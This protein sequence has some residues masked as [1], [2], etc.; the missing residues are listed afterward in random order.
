M[1][2]RILYFGH[3]SLAIY[4][5][6][7]LLD[8]GAEVVAVVPTTT[9]NAGEGH[10][11]EARSL[12]R[13][14][15]S[16][17]LRVERLPN[18]NSAAARA[19]LAALEPDLL[20]SVHYDRIFTPAVL[21]LPRLGA[22]NLHLSPLPRLRGCYPTKWAI[23]E[24][25]DA[26]VT[27]HCMDEGVDTGSIID[28]RIVPLEVAETDQSLTARLDAEARQLLDEHVPKWARG[29]CG[30]ATPQDE[31]RA[32]YHPAELPAGGRLDLEG[33]V[34]WAERMVRAFTFPG[35]PGATLRWD[36]DE[37]EVLAPVRICRES[38]T[39]P[40]RI[41]LERSGELAIGFAD[42]TLYATRVRW[43]GEEQ[44]P[45][46]LAELEERVSITRATVRG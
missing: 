44:S 12:E 25:E 33:S 30:E 14:A 34:E 17:E 7:R 6:E 5:L 45:R 13:F 9:D 4:G 11:D 24:G 20:I 39:A 46:D 38:T 42:G 36:E 35:Q 43:R 29:E 37:I 15:R 21:E 8:A 27:L 40:G 18:P 23:L 41:R 19:T 3:G 26:G 10:L 22:L 16:R 1:H 32:S 2:A 28:R 31:A